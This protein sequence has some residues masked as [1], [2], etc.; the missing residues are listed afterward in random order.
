MSQDNAFLSCVLLIGGESIESSAFVTVGL[1]GG[2]GG[3]ATISHIHITL[4]PNNIRKCLFVAGTFL[5]D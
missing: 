3:V 4:P 5:I 1:Y 2:K